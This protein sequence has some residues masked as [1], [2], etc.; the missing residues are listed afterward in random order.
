MFGRCVDRTTDSS[1]HGRPA[2]TRSVRSTVWLSTLVGAAFVAVVLLVARSPVPDYLVDVTAG[3]AGGA[4]A[5]PPAAIVTSTDVT[6]CPWLESAIDRHESPAALAALVVGRMTLTEKIGEIVLTRV[7]PYENADA[8]VARLCIPS[9]TLQ[10]G[11][12]GLAA[13]ATHVTQLP[14]P[15]G[16]AATFDPSVANDYG[17]VLGEE[18]S[19]QGFDVVQGPTLNVLRVPETGRAYEGYGEDPL[20]VSAMGVADIRGIQSEG[21]M[22]QAKHFAAYSQETD[23]GELD[24]VVPP[25][26]LNE[27]YLPPFLAAVSQAH[28]ASVMCAYPQL[29]GTF[30]CQDG[31]LLGL[32][33]TWGFGGFVR[34]DLGAVHDPVAAL[35]AGTDLIKPASQAKLI[36][37]ARAGHLPVRVVDTAVRQVLAQMFAYGV[38]GRT[39]AG[40]PGT[41]VDTA[42]HADF[43]LRAAERS[44][45]LLKNTGPVLP[46]DASRLRSLAVIGAD[47]KSAPVTTGFG[48]SRVLAPFTSSPLSAIRRRAGGGVAVTYSDGGS[49]TAPLPP[50]PSAYLTPASGSGHGLTL[51]LTQTDVDTGPQSIQ[52]V[53]PTV[54]VGISPHPAGQLLPTPG[55]HAP[56]VVPGSANLARGP[57][58][59]GRRAFAQAVAPSERSRIVLPAGWSDV[60]AA[61]S[62][63]LTPPRSG[64]YTLSLQG[65]GGASLTLDG[66]T[67][68]S[69]TLSHAGGRWSQTVPLVGGHSYKVRLSW[70]PFDSLTPSGENATTAGSFSLGW[71]YASDAIDAAA[72][73][74]RHAQVA[75]VFAGDYNAEAFDRPSLA[76]PSDENALIAAVAAANPR[77]VVV[78]NTGGPVLMPWLPK[79]AGV[80]EAWYPGEEDGA[81]IS[82]LLFGDVDPSGRLPVTFPTS[83]AATAVSSPSQWP[84]VNLTAT[85]SEGLDIGYRYNHATGVQPLFPF[86]FGLAYTTFALSGLTATTSAAGVTLSFVVSD[87]GTNPGVAVPQAY[88]TMP[89]AAGQPPSQLAA[90]T[91]VD[92]T[93]GQSTT[94]DLTV[95]SSAFQSYVGS[96][97]TTVPGTYTLS[98]GQSSADLPLS[99]PVQVP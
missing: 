59:L 68:V 66:A 78:L 61:W 80:V 65:S 2:R 20:L 38:V 11:P 55:P 27:L 76:L 96:S 84:G 90:F 69:D 25:Q 54:D 12:Q 35:T 22:A 15:L 94:V 81:S 91:T 62:G 60:S 50:V 57:L 8:G 7:G 53:Q 63:T 19:G 77:T 49:T 67:V 79:V 44:A 32:L 52:T 42:A 40:A 23:R 95:P 86:G 14:A 33:G 17:Q 64:L 70:E 31:Q 93:P 10:D 16:I 21:V 13:G 85:Y 82:A 43:A 89:S 4:Q 26:A 29:N 74:A 71:Q 97:W 72:A 41:P 28:V 56:P 99:V 6:Q 39:P 98:V 87:T 88:I 37:L 3:N 48:S 9:L 18:A 36:R 24:D 45:V 83:D 34:S 5:T 46:L 92:L 1:P 51:T 30:Q 75:V 73:A 58:S 47:A